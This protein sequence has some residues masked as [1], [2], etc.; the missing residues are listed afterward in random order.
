MGECELMGTRAVDCTS[1]YRGPF[2]DAEPRPRNFLDSAKLNSPM[3]LT[4]CSLCHGCDRER[5]SCPLMLP[6]TTP[7]SEWLSPNCAP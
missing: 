4:S 7:G 3:Q 6:G 2:T 1:T 5:Y